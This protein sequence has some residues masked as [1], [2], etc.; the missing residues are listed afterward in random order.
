MGVRAHARWAERAALTA[1]ATSSLVDRGR[2]AR[3]APPIGEWVSRCSARGEHTTRAVS[4]RT[5]AGSTAYVAVGSV[6][7]SASMSGAIGRG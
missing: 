7:G 5:T 4:L 1:E 2:E 3:G 6:S